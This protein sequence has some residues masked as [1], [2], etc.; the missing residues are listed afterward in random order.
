[1][2]LRFIEI[3]ELLDRANEA[4][5]G[6]S[7]R[8]RDAF[9]RRVRDG[10]C[11]HELQLEGVPVRP[12]DIQRVHAGEE[13]ADYCDRMLLEQIR[14]TL[15]LLDD[16]RLAAVEGR[17]I[18]LSQ[19]KTWQA[20]LEVEP[21]GGALREQS[22]PT[23]HYKH[24]VAEP[25]DHL[26]LAEKTLAALHE[27]GGSVH[28]LELATESLFNMMRAWPFN[29]W[30]GMIA[31]LVASVALIRGGYPPLLVGAHQRQPFYQAMHYDLARLEQVV[32]TALREE[33]EAQARTFGATL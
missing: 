32:L 2:H 27:R 12:E 6:A 9:D 10:W 18:D 21:K 28:P 33:L 30:S 7:Q 20:T 8:E 22:G 5:L 1:M 31:R 4:R 16:V 29:L 17:R 14:R 11:F 25:P 3:D 19:L 26:A 24:D 23:E 15:S 13:G